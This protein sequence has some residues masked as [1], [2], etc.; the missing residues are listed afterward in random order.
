MPMHNKEDFGTNADG[1]QSCDYCNYCF[2]NGAFTEPSL[3]EEQMI[4]KVSTVM[5]KLNMTDKQIAEVKAVIPNLKRW[6]I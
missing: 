6:G 4:K 5:K 2:A 3:T 1:S